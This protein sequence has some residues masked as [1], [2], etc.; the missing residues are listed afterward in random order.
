MVGNENLDFYSQEKNKQIFKVSIMLGFTFI[1]KYLIIGYSLHVH[2]LF[3]VTKYLFQVDEIIVPQ[4]FK[5]VHIG[6]SS[7][8]DL[9]LLK[10]EKHITLN[11]FAL[12][13]CLPSHDIRLPS[14]ITVIIVLTYG[15][16]R[17]KTI[18][19]QTHHGNPF[20]VHP[21]FYR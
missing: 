8:F 16:Q 11:S 9:A 18:S 6:G 21:Y 20:L 14:A 17:G 1:C 5:S 7:E 3:P 13:V 15:S 19:P 10:I 4:Q 2:T 12:P